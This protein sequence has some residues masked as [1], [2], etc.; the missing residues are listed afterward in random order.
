M[1]AIRLQRTG[2][3]GHANYR[4]VVQDSRQTPTSGKVVALLGSYDPHTKAISLTKDKAELFL[5][6]GAQPSERVVR[7][8]QKEGLKLPKWVKTPTKKSASIKNVDK[9]RRN[10]PEPE[11]VESPEPEIENVA[12]ITSDQPNEETVPA[13]PP[14]QESAETSPETSQ[15]TPPTDNSTGETTDSE[16][17]DAAETPSPE[18]KTSDQNET[19]SPEIHINEA[20]DKTDQKPPKEDE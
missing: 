6:N 4:V 16:T 14:E 20:K 18:E 7:L 15:Q 1:L 17:T 12:E 9:L 10:R 3:K 19:K 2:R 8:F 5:N 13:N 11:P